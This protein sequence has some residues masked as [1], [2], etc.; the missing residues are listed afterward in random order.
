MKN[1]FKA[2]HTE[3]HTGSL[4]RLM[5]EEVISIEKYEEI[6]RKRRMARS[7][8]DSMNDEK[9]YEQRSHSQQHSNALRRQY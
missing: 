4:K 2:F 6:Q 8:V 9:Y 1:V 3:K 5:N 7:K